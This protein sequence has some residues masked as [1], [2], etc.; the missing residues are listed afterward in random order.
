MRRSAFPRDSVLPHIDFARRSPL[1]AVGLFTT[2]GVV[3]AL[4][5][6]LGLAVAIGLGSMVS[7]TIARPAAPAPA[8]AASSGFDPARYMLNAFL[9][10][11]LDDDMPLRW[12][13]PRPRLRCGPA[14]AVRVNGAPL[15]TGDLVPD[16]P[17]EMDWSADD[18]HP[19]GV[20]GPRIDGAFRMTVFREDWGFSAMVVPNGLTAASGGAQTRIRRGAATYP[21]CPAGEGP[22]ACR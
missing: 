5:Y 6:A 16:R 21:L 22:A 17:F 9:V 2:V 1:R 8:P 11:A 7:A 20:G 10:P 4:G 15:R 12:V 19:F 13:D 14:T 18:C 3:S